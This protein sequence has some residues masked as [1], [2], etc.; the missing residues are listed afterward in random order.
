MKRRMSRGKDKRVFR[1]T[2]VKTKK[3]NVAP[4]VQRG[5]IRL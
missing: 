2:A 1:Q 5:G 4:N 3:V